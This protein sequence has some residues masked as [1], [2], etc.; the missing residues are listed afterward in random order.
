MISFRLLPIAV[1]LASAIHGADSKKPGFQVPNSKEE[2]PPPEDRQ[3]T[4]KP[5]DPAPDFNLNVMHSNQTVRL[6]GFKGKRPV[7]LIFGSYT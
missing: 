1:C 6:A 7:A 3:G 2:A 5:G 4:L